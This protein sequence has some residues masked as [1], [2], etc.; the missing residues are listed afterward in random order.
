MSSMSKKEFADV[1]QQVQDLQAEGRDSE[2]EPLLEILADDLGYVEALCLRIP[3]PALK[4]LRA[5][6]KGKFW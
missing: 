3:Q 6:P 2:L 5:D 1:I 4:Q